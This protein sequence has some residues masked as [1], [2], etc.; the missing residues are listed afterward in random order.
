MRL[1]SK[2]DLGVLWAATV[3]VFVV[4]AWASSALLPSGAPVTRPPV[5]YYVG[6]IGLSSIG[7]SLLL[8]WRWVFRTGPTTNATRATIKVLLVVLSVVWA[9][10]MIFP[11]L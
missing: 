2:R 8:T 10:A 1:Q 6:L 9:C 5:S 11:F 4:S 3:T 7:L